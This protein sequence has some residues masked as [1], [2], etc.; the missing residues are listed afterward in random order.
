MKVTIP[1]FQLA[2]MLIIGDVMLDRY[3]TGQA[4]RISPEAPVPVVNVNSVEERPGGAG[5]VAMNLASLGIRPKL[6]GVIGNDD[7]GKKL[8]RVL[9]N[10]GVDTYLQ[11]LSDYPTVTKL[12]VLSQHQQLIRLDFE[13]TFYN[14]KDITIH[15]DCI[16]AIENVGAV[17]IS[18]YHKGT[19]QNVQ[20]IISTANRLNIPV[21]VD[22]KGAS[23]D[24]YRGADVLTPNRREF[25]QVVG[26]CH[27][28]EDIVKKGKAALIAHGIGALLVTRGSEGMTLIR[29]DQ[30]PIHL[31]ARAFEV[32]D[33]TGAGDTVI[34]VIAAAVAAGEN[35]ANAMYLANIAA[36]IVVT[37]LGA[38]QV[39]VPELR[40]EL[41]KHQYSRLGVLTEE[42]AV[43]AI[44]DAKS[45]QE[46]I[47]MTNGCFDI[48]HPGH[49]GY[50]EAA[51]SLGDRLIVAVNSDESIARNKGPSRPV[52]KLQDRMAVLAGLRVVDWVFPFYEETPQRIIELLTPDV[53]VKGVDY[54]NQNIVGADHVLAHGGEVKFVGPEK[55]WS[56][57][58]LIEK[59]METVE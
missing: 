40:R 34:A 22:P 20:Q 26:P 51:K 53:L 10:K 59:M 13:E 44:E 28:E 36:G 9:Q 2:R 8:H 54:L 43:M 1:N 49:I 47:V 46:K 11:A 4:K 18:D 21:F 19:L 17:V 25:E 57:S 7:A 23:F 41:R 42:E 58:A 16:D 3:W 52:K 50:L 29:R 6:F 55:E 38:A 27:S 5:N 12:R 48:L 24:R 37:K 14:S 15:H 30:D 33:V 31:T 35:F 39:S 32:Y 56:S 45:R